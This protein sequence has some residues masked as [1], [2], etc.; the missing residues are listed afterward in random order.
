VYSLSNV[1][2]CFQLMSG[3]LFLFQRGTGAEVLQI[4]IKRA[5]EY[6]QEY[7]D[8]STPSHKQ[9]HVNP[10]LERGCK[11]MQIFCQAVLR[12][13]GPDFRRLLNTAIFAW[14][15]T[16][17]DQAVAA[18][19]DAGFDPKRRSGQVYG[20]GE[21]FGIRAAI[22]MGYAGQT[23]RLI[24]AGLLRVRETTV[25]R[26]FCYVVDNPCDCSVA[27]CLPILV[28]SYDSKLP[29]IPWILSAPQPLPP[30]VVGAVA[31][32]ALLSLSSAKVGEAPADVYIA[33]FR[34][35]WW[36][37]TQFRPYTEDVSTM[38]ESNLANYNERG[39]PPRFT[40]APII[41]FLDDV[42]QMYTIDFLRS[43]QKHPRTQNE[44]RIRRSPVRLGPEL[45][46]Q[47]EVLGD[48]GAWQ[49]MD[50]LVVDRVE[51]AFQQY[52]RGCGPSEIRNLE[53][54]GRPERYTVS[55]VDG[56]QRNETSNKIRRVR[57]LA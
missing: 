19:C 16:K 51:S 22:S 49:K 10:C 2:R 48:D 33:P 37:D 15:G 44:R 55:F 43:V 56:T 54:V 53:V 11:A 4:L 12:Q 41:R 32:T 31:T 52:C 24:V 42:P 29:E 28:L 14:H 3:F 57:R 40:T 46:A 5:K 17:S 27:F 39:G 34:W 18:I 26:D 1:F 50:R 36:D 23:N 38:I 13:G 30:V 25:H 20:R 6:V 35:E 7:F 47:W 45:Q 21:Y 9:M 8:P